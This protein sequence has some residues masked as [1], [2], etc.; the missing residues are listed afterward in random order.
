MNLSSI[1][2]AAA[3]IPRVIATQAQ[4]FLVGIYDVKRFDDGLYDEDGLTSDHSDEQCDEGGQ[5]ERLTYSGH[6]RP[7]RSKGSRRYLDRER[8]YHSGREGIKADSEPLVYDDG[9]GA[10]DGGDEEGDV[11]GSED[12][13]KYGGEKVYATGIASMGPGQALGEGVGGGSGVTE[14][15]RRET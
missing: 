10:P 9:N 15:V 8:G 13:E 5:V 1:L 2:D 7:Q 12:G 11:D 14:E 4:A 3:A 6:W